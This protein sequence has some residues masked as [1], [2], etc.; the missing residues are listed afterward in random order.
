[1]QKAVVSTS[2]GCE[3][4]AVESGKHLSVQDEPDAFAQEVITLLRSPEQRAAYGEAGRALV[5]ATYSWEQC[6]TRL[7][8]AL[9]SVFTERVRV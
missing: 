3:G 8:R 2:L 5:E 1:M 6:G 7:L 4:I 9:D